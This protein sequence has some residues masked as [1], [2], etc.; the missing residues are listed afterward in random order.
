M[1]LISTVVVVFPKDQP[2]LK[3]EPNLTVEQKADFLLHAKVIDSH[4]TSKGVTNPWRLTLTDGTITH[5]AS[6]QKVDERKSVMT[7]ASG[8]TE[9]NFK[10]SY[11]FNVAAYELAK[12]IG[13][14]DM[15]P[16]T[17]AR[18]WKGDEGSLTWWIPW[19]WD[20][21]M[22]RDQHLDPPD[23]DGWNKQMY[24]KRVFAQLVYDTDPNLTNLLITEDWKIWM[25][26]FTRAF[27]VS[28][29]IQ[30]PKDLE[31]CDKQLLERLRKLDGDEL[32]A[33]TKGHLSKS[34]VQAVMARR[35][36]IVAH[37][38]KLVAEKG[39]SEVLY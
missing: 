23:P 22:R 19:K 39:E 2:S 16:V 9:I 11:H 17:V 30:N 38:E 7:L 6:F 31:K 21:V 36:K 27:R 1:V 18:K 33:K 3:D 12:L 13:L 5:N 37:F 28:H 20:E 10:D 26:D 25:I 24:R 15:M 29:D 14:D 34:E 32:A 8:R 35:D 4:Q